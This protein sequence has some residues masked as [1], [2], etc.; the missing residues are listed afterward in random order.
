MHLDFTLQDQE[1]VV[2]QID[3]ELSELHRQILE[4]NLL[5]VVPVFGSVVSVGGARDNNLGSR[6]DSKPVGVGGRVLDVL[7]VHGDRARREVLVVGRVV[8]QAAVHK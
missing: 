1:S 2:V 5:A 3:P 4:G 7:E 6:N 8:D